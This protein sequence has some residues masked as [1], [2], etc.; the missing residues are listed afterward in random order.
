MSLK[1]TL[2]LLL[3]LG[4]S[5]AVAK[6]DPQSAVYNL[7]ADGNK[8]QEV[9][10]AADYF[11]DANSVEEDDDESETVGTKRQGS[12]EYPY[13]ADAGNYAG[14]SSRADTAAA[15]APSRYPYP[16]PYPYYG[17]PPYPSY[18]Y[19]Y[20][21]YP[22]PAYVPYNTSLGSCHSYLMIAPHV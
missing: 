1:F 7:E 11:S 9:Y 4:C 19:P 13:D 21:G 14:L 15:A 17:Y 10:V 20:Y 3:A 22:P 6:E 5:L 18:P 2:C 12:F 16:Y 8:D